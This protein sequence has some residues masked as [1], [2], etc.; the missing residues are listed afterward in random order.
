MKIKHGEIKTEYNEIYTKRE[1]ERERERE[2]EII[3]EFNSNAGIPT[4]EENYW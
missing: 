2:T 3:S 1:R 4:A